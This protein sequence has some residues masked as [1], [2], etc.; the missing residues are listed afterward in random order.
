MES[1]TNHAAPFP[2]GCHILGDTDG[3]RLTMSDCGRSRVLKLRTGV[4][5]GRV[6][7]SA[8][9][10]GT[11]STGPGAAHSTM[12]VV[13]PHRNTDGEEG[14][15]TDSPVRP[16]TATERPGL[17]R[18]TVTSYW[19]ASPLRMIASVESFAPARGAAL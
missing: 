6:Y 1:S 13:L 12:R 17:S 8:D 2:S 9:S 10:S 18:A 5:I 3:V 15:E 7:I 4:S 11:M 19:P 16:I 14:A